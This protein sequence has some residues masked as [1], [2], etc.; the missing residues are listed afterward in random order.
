MAHAEFPGLSEQDIQGAVHRK[1]DDLQLIAVLA[2]DIEGL[3]T[4][5]SRRAEYRNAPVWP[6]EPLSL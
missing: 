3:G 6:L 2:H 1:A 5:G 4:D